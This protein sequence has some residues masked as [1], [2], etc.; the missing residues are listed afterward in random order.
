MTEREIL[1]MFIDDYNDYSRLYE[2]YKY[3]LQETLDEELFKTLHEYEAKMNLLD[4]YI[5]AFAEKLNVKVANCYRETFEDL[6]RQTKYKFNKYQ[7][8]EQKPINFK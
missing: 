8:I 2:A 6:N 3:D 5:K 7:I 1:E 4:R